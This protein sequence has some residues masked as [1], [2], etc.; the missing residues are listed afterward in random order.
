MQKKMICSL[1]CLICLIS[2]S[3][4]NAATVWKYVSGG[5]RDSDFRA[6]AIDPESVETVYISSPEAV[7]K[8]T[9]GGERWE[10]VFSVRS[11]GNTINTIAVDAGHVYVGTG[12]GLYRSKD[13]GKRWERIFSSI[14]N[15]ERGVLFVT[16]D[17][18][19]EDA[20][21]IGTSSGFFFS[22]N[23]GHN[24]GKGRNLPSGSGVHYI[25]VDGSDPRTIYAATD[26]GVYKSLNRGMDWERIFGTNV[27]EEEDYVWDDDEIKEVAEMA[28]VR[29]IVI[30]PEDNRTL[31]AGTSKGLLISMDSGQTWK[32]AGSLGLRSRDIRH[33]AAQS[34][35]SI[36]T[37]TDRGGYI[38]SMVSQSWDEAYE[39]L[40]SRE[41]RYIAAAK[42]VIW[43]A[44]DKGV[45][46][47]VTEQALALDRAINIEEVFLEFADEP[48]IEE[49][50][51]AAIIYA[52]VHPSKIRKWRTAAARKALLPDLRIGF[53]KNRDWQSS[54]YFYSTSSQKYSDDDITQGNDSGWSVSLTWELGELIWNNDQTS[55]DSRARYAVQLRD[56]LLNEVT[57]LFFERRRL[58][59]AML[60]SP[61]VDIRERI[62]YEI[63][64][65]ELTAGIDALT[66]SYLSKRLKKI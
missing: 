36:Y 6:V 12:K 4:V 34:G 62:E 21:F 32:A 25:S 19:N 43:A 2:A 23:G 59:L 16:V 24:W 46:K 56:D 31:F 64:L 27:P 33:L 61:H 50:R 1:V 17:S 40:A 52:D 45:F 51:Q 55:I 8:T 37:A 65:Q 44:A 5:I 60:I 22:K 20:I 35:G 39:G 54:T 29:C 41:I 7:Y 42:G 28:E 11:T 66:D 3:L 48:T 14:G 47:T 13:K 58:Q 15:G 18:K 26:K 53:D 10:V 30:D 38:Y 63:R 49:I 57:R 9:D